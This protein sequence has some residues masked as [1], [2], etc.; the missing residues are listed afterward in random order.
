MKRTLLI[1]RLLSVL[2]VIAAPARHAEAQ[3]VIPA[4]TS[5]FVRPP[6]APASCSNVPITMLSDANRTNMTYNGGTTS[7]CPPGST[8][9]Q[10]QSDMG[11]L[12]G[13]T[14]H[15]ITN[16]ASS[17]LHER[18][19]IG[20]AYNDNL[21][22]QTEFTDYFFGMDF[23]IYVEGVYKTHDNTNGFTASA[24]TA[25]EGDLY[26]IFFYNDAGTIKAQAK[27]YREISPGVGAWHFIFQFPNVTAT[28]YIYVGGAV[29]DGCVKDFV[30]CGLTVLL[31]P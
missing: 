8:T 18:M 23:G 17:S 22:G 29:A 15:I 12:F 3:L 5:A 14:G 31:A 6:A 11:I 19:V 2:L 9:G 27:Y 25:N 7:W 26:G 16:Y 1:V 4:R 20:M 24:I 21:D 10:A 28:T 30:G 13:D